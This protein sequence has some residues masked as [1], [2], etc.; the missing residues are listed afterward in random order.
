MGTTDSQAEPESV[1]STA[2]SRSL[3]F[4][5]KWIVFVLMEM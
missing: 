1:D 3:Q 2:T 5:S 4:K